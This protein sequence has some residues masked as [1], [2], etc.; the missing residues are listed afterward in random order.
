LKGRGFSRAVSVAK[1]MA[2]LAADALPSYRDDFP[3]ACSAVPFSAW[4]N[5]GF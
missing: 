3:A 1:L 4:K 2:A 5:V